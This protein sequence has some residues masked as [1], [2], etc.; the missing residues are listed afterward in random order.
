MKSFQEDG[1]VLPIERFKC[2]RRSKLD[3]TKI[4][5][6]LSTKD[7]QKEFYEVRPV[8]A[9]N[10]SVKK[11]WVTENDKTENDLDAKTK[12]N[13]LGGADLYCFL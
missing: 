13:L 4:V 2:F 9:L 12:G 10:V 8:E 6:K 3:R 1:K 5:R 11:W 7:L